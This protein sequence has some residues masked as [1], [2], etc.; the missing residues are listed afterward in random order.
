MRRRLKRFLAFLC[1]F[2]LVSGGTISFAVAVAGPCAHERGAHAGTLH[3]DH[4]HHGAGCL[5]CC[6][7]ACTVVPALPAP[8]SAGPVIFSVTAA[9]YWESAVALD[10]R[11]I[12]PDPGPPR[13]IT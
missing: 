13:T 10:S 5:A 4:D 1:V 12:A 11:S 8:L 6:L 7:G 2:A 3:H 9:A